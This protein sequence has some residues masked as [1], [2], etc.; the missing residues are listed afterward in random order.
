MQEVD[1]SFTGPSSTRWRAGPATSGIVPIA[2]LLPAEMKFCGRF[3][4]RLDQGRRASSRFYPAGQ[5]SILSRRDGAARRHT[6]AW[7]ALI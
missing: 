7:H 3:K 4:G 5:I 6:W 2:P 1:L